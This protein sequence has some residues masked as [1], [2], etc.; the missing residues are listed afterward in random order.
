MRVSSIVLADFQH[1]HGATVQI[2]QTNTALYC[3][4]MKI[5][6]EDDEAVLDLGVHE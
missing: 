6:I 2:E 3:K 1:D 5:I 4:K